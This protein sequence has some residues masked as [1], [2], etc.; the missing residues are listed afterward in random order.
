[1]TSSSVDPDLTPAGEDDGVLLRRREWLTALFGTAVAGGVWTPAGAADALQ[2]A[3]ATAAGPALPRP[4]LATLTAAA[5]VIAP[6]TK[7]PGAVD[8]G[9]PAFIAALYQHWMTADERNV[10]TEGLASLDQAAMTAHRKTFARCS[11]T[12]RQALLQALREAQPFKGFAMSVVQR[13]T[14]P[15][16]PFFTRLRD[17]VMFG[18]YTSQAGTTQALRYIPAPGSYETVKTADWPYQMVL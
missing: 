16:A 4:A 9:V 13:I 12:Q 2:K 18:F 14:D 1:M 6:R 3:G 8:A 5:D 15:K 11:P 7:T 17:L 10:F